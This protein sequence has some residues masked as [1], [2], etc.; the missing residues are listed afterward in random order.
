MART[1]NYEIREAKNKNGEDEVYIIPLDRRLWEKYNIGYTIIMLLIGA[2]IS[3]LSNEL[4]K[5]WQ[6]SKDIK[7]KYELQVHHSQKNDSITIYSIEIIDSSKS[8]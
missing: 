3:L 8:K 5:L 6:Q 2:A 7:P 1:R 4:P